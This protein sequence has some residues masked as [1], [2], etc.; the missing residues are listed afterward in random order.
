MKEKYL[1][2]IAAVVVI[3]IVFFMWSTN[4]VNSKSLQI[5]RLD[6]Q[7]RRAQERL[8]SAKVL[9]EQ[10]AQ[11][12]RVIEN[13]LTTDREFRSVEI[14]AL[15]RELAELADHYQIAVYSLSPRSAFSGREIVEHQ[16]I[17]DVMATY[18]Q[19]GQFM[20]AL[21]SFDQIIR[22]NKLDVKP[23][24]TPFEF[25]VDGEPVTQYRV[26]IEISAFKIVKEG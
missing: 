21:E 4:I 10:L 23:Q 19:L 6:A 9:N 20:T 25:I 1:G 14:N 7:I 13:V 17:M 22:V 16:F 18:V 8:N 15:V 12:S 11:V 3:S 26:N 24:D 5:R 2:F